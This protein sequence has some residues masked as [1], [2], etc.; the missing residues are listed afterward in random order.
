MIE[1]ESVAQDHYQ[2]FSQN[3]HTIPLESLIQPK[4]TKETVWKSQAGIAGK[5]SN[6]NKGFFHPPLIL[7]V[8]C[9]NAV[10][11]YA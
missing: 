2:V 7:T 10:Y 11:H 4:A 1:L 9:S 3:V 5:G 8:F 6:S